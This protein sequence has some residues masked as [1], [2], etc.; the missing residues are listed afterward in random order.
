MPCSS[1]L[2]GPP[3]RV[4]AEQLA[5]LALNHGISSFFLYRVE[6]ADLLRRFAAEV[7]PAVREIVAAH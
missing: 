1:L 5:D 2:K 7:V 4:W 6:E 3:S